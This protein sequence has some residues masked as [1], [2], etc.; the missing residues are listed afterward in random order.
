MEGDARYTVEFEMPAAQNVYVLATATE[1]D[2]WTS[3]DHFTFPIYQYAPRDSW[4][5]RSDPYTGSLEAER[6]CND[7]LCFTCR[8]NSVWARWRITRV[9]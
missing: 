2:F 5:A 7:A 3:D 1:L 8:E 4:G 9:R 6:D